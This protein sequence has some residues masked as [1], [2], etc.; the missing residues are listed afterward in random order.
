MLALLV[1]IQLGGAVHP[2]SESGLQSQLQRRLGLLAS[3]AAKLSLHDAARSTFS[4]SRVACL[5]YGVDNLI[6]TQAQAHQ[7]VCTQPE[8]LRCEMDV[9]YEDDHVL[10]LNKPWDVQL[11]LPDGIARWEGMIRRVDQPLCVR[12]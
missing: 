10:C 3:D 6:L 8:Y 12:V 2:P 11:N 1:A 7:L 9:A 4:A 5:S